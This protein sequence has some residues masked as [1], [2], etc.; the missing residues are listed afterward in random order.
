MYLTIPVGTKLV[1][2]IQILR[3][4]HNALHFVRREEKSF[5]QC[6]DSSSRFSRK[7]GAP[8]HAR[9]LYLRTSL[10]KKYIESKNLPI[11]AHLAK[12]TDEGILVAG[13]AELKDMTHSRR[14]S[15][16]DRVLEPG[17]DQEPSTGRNKDGLHF[18]SPF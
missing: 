9:F 1:R 4:S 18:L 2:R 8:D 15:H 6:E 14:T 10:M 16:W 5:D 13:E 11:A 12:D 17:K 7:K 3:T